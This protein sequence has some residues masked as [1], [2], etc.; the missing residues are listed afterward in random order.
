M[1][2]VG[3]VEDPK[4][5][6]YKLVK[7]W[8][9]ALPLHAEYGTNPNVFYIPPL[10]PPR[11]DA[12]GKLDT[13]KPRIPREYLRFLFGP[14]VDAALGVMNTELEKVK[15]GG[16][17]ELMDILIARQWTH[18]FGPF[19]KDPATLERKPAQPGS[20]SRNDLTALN[21]EKNR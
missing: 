8:K 11:L 3:Y 5:I 15:S 12:E 20:F 10:A 6:I 13:T 2:W 16:K 4:S 7:V 19:D 18:M 21:N 1:R 17:S 9:V 14:E